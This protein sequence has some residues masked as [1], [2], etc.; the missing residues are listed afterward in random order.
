MPP[1]APLDMNLWFLYLCLQNSDYKSVS[2]ESDYV[3][4]SAAK[5]NPG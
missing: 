5:L 1:K 2:I 3:V 4:D